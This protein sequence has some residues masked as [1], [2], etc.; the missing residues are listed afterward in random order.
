[1]TQKCRGFIEKVIS[2]SDLRLTFKTIITLY[3]L[4]G[5]LGKLC[6][7][8][9]LLLIFVNLVVFYAKIEKRYPN[10]LYENLLAA[11]Q[12]V[13]GVISLID[14]FVPRYEGKDEE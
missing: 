9:L 14:V 3:L 2:L 6:Y 12:M 10:F 7:D 13:D 11:N 8:V 1:M 4:S 5:I